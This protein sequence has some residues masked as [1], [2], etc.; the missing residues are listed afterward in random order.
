MQV[1]GRTSYDDGLSFMSRYGSGYGAR[2]G[3]VIF[4]FDMTGRVS[5]IHAVVVRSLGPNIQFIWNAKL[6]GC[7]DFPGSKQRCKAS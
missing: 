3:T 7:S 1:S 4:H 2:S 5:S 6:G